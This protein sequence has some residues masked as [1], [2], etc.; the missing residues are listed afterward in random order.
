MP[1]LYRVI[2]AAGCGDREGGG[3]CGD[4]EGGAGCGDTEGGAGRREGSV[5]RKIA[6]LAA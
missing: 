4:R 3:G 2:E 5:I 1:R 6:T